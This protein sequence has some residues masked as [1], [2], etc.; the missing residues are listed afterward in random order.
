[1]EITELTVHELV[2]KMKSKELTSE[3]IT[4]AYAKR[5]DEKENDIKRLA[6]FV[7]ISIKVFCVESVIK[8]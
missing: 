4:R 7:L 5:I 2:E 8:K 1:M 6:S 3:E